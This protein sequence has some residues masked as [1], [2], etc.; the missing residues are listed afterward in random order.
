MSAQFSRATYVVCADLSSG[1]KLGITY[2]PASLEISS[3]NPEGLV[4]SWNAS[5]PEA[6]V[7]PGD[8]ILEVNGK[9]S[10]KLGA[11]A[12]QAEIN[13]SQMLGISFARTLNF[14]MRLDTRSGRLGLRLDPDSLQV[15]AID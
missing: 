7:R 13:K 11:A 2:E 4:A 10:E 5:H 12:V 1:A 6:I 14:H 15:R 8:R 3:I 9:S